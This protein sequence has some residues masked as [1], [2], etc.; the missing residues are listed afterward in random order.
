MELTCTRVIAF[1]VTLEANARRV[2][3]FRVLF[4][5]IIFSCLD[6]DDCASWPCNNAGR[7]ID[8][9]DSFTCQCFPGFTG[10]QCETSESILSSDLLP[11]TKLFSGL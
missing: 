1:L 7:C 11:L 9:I 2:R 8:E 10:V 3:V 4:S 6:I 5:I